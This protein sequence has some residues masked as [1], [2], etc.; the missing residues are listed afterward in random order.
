M[1]ARGKT[2]GA[3][4]ILFAFLL[5]S[6]LFYTLP[7]L[8]LGIPSVAHLLETIGSFNSSLHSSILNLLGIESKSALDL[9][10]LPTG[11]VLKYSP[12]CFGFLTIAGLTLLIFIAPSI[13]MVNRLKWF[14]IAAISLLVLNQFRILFEI[15]IA[16]LY[17]SLVK[18]A[19]TALYP[20]LPGVA[21]LLWIWGLQKWVD[22]PPPSGVMSD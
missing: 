3:V 15:F 22:D 5:S 11:A 7:P 14:F 2:Y 19:D 18:K 10:Y 4:T 6:V 12:Y 21:M 17:P 9:L 8:L 13:N 1:K 20:L 16:L